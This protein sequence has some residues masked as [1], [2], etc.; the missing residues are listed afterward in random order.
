LRR[1]FIGDLK[2]ILEFQEIQFPNIARVMSEEER[3]S[4]LASTAMAHITTKPNDQVSAGGVWPQEE[5]QVAASGLVEGHEQPLP[6][7]ES[8][9]IDNLAQP[10]AC[11]LVV[12]V[13]GS[14]WMEVGKE[15]VYPHQTLL[16]DVQ[17]D[18]SP[19]VVVKV[20][21]VHEN[22]KNMKLEVALHD[23]ML[24]L[25]DTITRRFQ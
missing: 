1:E 21:M 12:M 11:I 6:S 13:R 4:R 7:L 22:K 8:D 5:L 24:T 20:D 16:D 25:Q 19:Y 14:Y 3:R 17:I 9:T 18:T 23:T 2:P 10:I 15:L